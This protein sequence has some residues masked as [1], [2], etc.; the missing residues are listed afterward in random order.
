MGFVS[1]RLYCLFEASDDVLPPPENLKIFKSH[2]DG[3]YPAA[4]SHHAAASVLIHSQIAASGICSL[5]LATI[6]SAAGKGNPAF[7]D[8]ASFSCFDYCRT[9]NMTSPKCDE[10]T[11]DLDR[12]CKTSRW[13]GFTHSANDVSLSVGFFNR[14]ELASYTRRPSGDSRDHTTL[15]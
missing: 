5:L 12:G 7:N 9:R 11:T 3:Y 6:R 8:A 1:A 13:K 15:S 2:K 10:L 4:S 14:P